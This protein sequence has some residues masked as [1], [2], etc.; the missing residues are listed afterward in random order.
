ME[1]LD[2]R[3]RKSSFSG[4]GGDCVEVG[5]LHD[6]AIAVRDTKDHNRGPVQRFTR[7]QWEAFTTGIRVGEFDLNES[8]ACRNSPSRERHYVRALSL[9]RAVPGH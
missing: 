8:A 7:A 6:G 4:N 5:Q 9:G 3:W 2:P 1:A